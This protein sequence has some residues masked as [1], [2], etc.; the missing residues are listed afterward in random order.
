MHLI[1]FFTVFW[2]HQT[3]PKNPK[4]ARKPPKMSPDSLQEPLKHKII[5]WIDF[6]AKIAP[7]M[8][9]KVMQTITKNLSNK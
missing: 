4:I 5:F 6:F 1:L 9:P 8:I 2:E 7:E 3:S